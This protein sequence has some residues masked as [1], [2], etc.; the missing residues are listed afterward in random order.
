MIKRSVFYVSLLLVVFS[1][2][3]IKMSK[4]VAELSY[5]VNG[6]TI[7]SKGGGAQYIKTSDA[8]SYN[9]G[10][11]GPDD[12]YCEYPPE[13]SYYFCLKDNARG[14][15]RHF[16]IQNYCD[17]EPYFVLPYKGKEY[18]AISGEFILEKAPNKNSRELKGT[19]NA[20]MVTPHPY[21][22]PVTDSTETIVVTNGKF[23]YSKV[24]QGYYKYDD[25]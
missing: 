3:K 16:D 13:L 1:C 20:V 6:E 12:H 5:T 18:R 8:V 24:N 22:F 2:D 15:K 11:Y 14:T 4:Y 23:Y 7:T 21:L 10:L 19:F 25:E 17:V 9:T